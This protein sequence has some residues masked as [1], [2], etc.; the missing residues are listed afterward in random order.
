MIRLAS[1]EFVEWLRFTNKLEY[2]YEYG[3]ITKEEYDE[4][5]LT[6]PEWEFERMDK[7]KHLTSML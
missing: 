7:Q 4:L 1:P 6:Y 2:M 5:Y 3:K